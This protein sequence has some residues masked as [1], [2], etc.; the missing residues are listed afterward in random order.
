M[1]I[2]SKN[3]EGT[4]NLAFDLAQKIQNGEISSSNGALVIGLHG[5]L[6]AGK[7]TFMK[8]F[9]E[10]L[11]VKETIQSPTF[12]IMK[13]FNTSPP[14]PLLIK[15]RG[16]PSLRGRGEVYEKLVHID[17]YRLESGEE[18]KKLGW[19]EM[20]KDPKNIIC[21]EW[22]EKVED[23]LNDFIHLNFEHISE[24]ERKITINI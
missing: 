3:T 17:A 23:I 18:L 6:G 13:I 14:S 16:R 9:A 7:T 2:I 24:N 8:S 10:A 4:R 22:P 15:E 19:E 1:E 11:G 12:V 20:V 21:I 5:D